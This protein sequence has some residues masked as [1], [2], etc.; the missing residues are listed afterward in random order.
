MKLFFRSLIPAL[1][2]ALAWPTQA[3]GAEMD[4]TGLWK[5]YRNF[6]SEVQGELIVTR[7]NKTLQAD[8]AGHS[9]SMALTQKTQP[10]AFSVPGNKGSFEGYINGNEL[11]GQWT[12][13]AP[14]QV[15]QKMTSPVHFTKT[16]SNQ[17]TGMV[18]PR[19]SEFTFYLPVTKDEDGTYRTFLRNPD[20]NLGVYQNIKRIEVEG[21][22]LT[23]VGPSRRSGDEQTYFE[24]VLHRDEDYFS[25]SMSAY[26]GGTYDF[27]RVEDTGNS[28]FFPRG[29]NPEPYMYSV[30]VAVN[31]GWKTAHLEKV[32][33]RFD[34]LKQ[35]IEKE[36]DPAAT[37]VN[38]LDL[39]GILIARKGKLV[40]EQYFNGMHRNQPHDTRSASKSMA[41]LLVGASM[42]AG[43]EVSPQTKVYESVSPDVTTMTLDARKDMTLE[44]LLTMSSGFYCDDNDD[45]APGNENTMQEQQGEP[46]WYRYTLALP[47]AYEPGETAIYCSA[48]SN[49]IGAV[50]RATT[51]QPVSELFAQHIA[52]PLDI[53]RYY[54]GLQPTGEV[55]L[56][57]GAQWLPR[58]FMKIGQLML[59]NG[60]WN[61]KRIVSKQWVKNSIASQVEIDGREY[62]YQW[63][64]TEYPYKD[65]SVRAFFAG[66]NGG[67]VVM[68]IPELDLLVT[69]F[70]GNYSHR[71]SRYSNDVLIPDY[72]LKAVDE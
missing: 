25:V 5:A 9:F 44:H 1:L 47:M 30:P 60:T 46:D 3:D 37:S 4:L 51:G 53:K 31:D 56:G 21:D 35:M 41:S 68:G 33:I 15:G 16:K 49:L 70:G 57:G 54:L 59:N 62:G 58:D 11:S 50:L 52:Q 10:V 38:D 40:F 69:F 43:F 2:I 17:W 8:I 32:G 45:D 22:R 39:H 18:R 66:G 67:Q 71:M 64:I 72:I 20:R 13:P 36:I 6:G 14:V 61:G 24:G 23:F 7:T 26:R 19:Q 29:E 55:Y 34:P 42:Q 28:T 65:R 12:Q 27:H 48:N 63:W